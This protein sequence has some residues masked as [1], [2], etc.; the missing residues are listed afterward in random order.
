[1]KAWHCYSEGVDDDTHII[2]WAPTRGKA[3]QLAK[4]DERFDFAAFIDI[5]VTREQWADGKPQ[6]FYSWEF[7]EKL[8]AH[9]WWFFLSYETGII[10]EPDLPMIKA[11]GEVKKF[12][13]VVVIKGWTHLN[14]ARSA[15]SK[16]HVVLTKEE[17]T[18][19][20][21]DYPY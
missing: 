10:E 21:S 9:G 20:K 12:Q 15:W 14:A 6:D 3:R 2:V 7:I 11:Y 8:L 19:T 13:D 4:L 1:M 5:S 18:R 16:S 17:L